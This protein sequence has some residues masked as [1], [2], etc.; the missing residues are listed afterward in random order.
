MEVGLIVV[1]IT[2]KIKT[3]LRKS[4]NVYLLSLF[5]ANNA[6]PEPHKLTDL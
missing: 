6:E 1:A 4:S 3:K 2:T 5:T